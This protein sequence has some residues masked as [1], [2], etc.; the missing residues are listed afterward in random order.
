[1]KKEIKKK[2]VFVDEFEKMAYFS[3]NSQEQG[4]GLWTDR[5]PVE[6]ASETR[7]KFQGQGHKQYLQTKWIDRWAMQWAKVTEHRLNAMH[8]EKKIR[9]QNVCL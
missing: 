3:R 8:K 7:G 1:M 2:K 6:F 4:V 5:I 9:K